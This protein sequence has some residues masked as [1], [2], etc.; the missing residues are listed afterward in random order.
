[1]HIRPLTVVKWLAFIVVGLFLLKLFWGWITNMAP[2]IVTK[3][4]N[5][6]VQGA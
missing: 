5:T 3:S 4:I 6:V 2:N 1:M